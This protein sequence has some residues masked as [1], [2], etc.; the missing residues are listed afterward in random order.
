[1]AKG[2]TMTDDIELRSHRDRNI[3]SRKWLV[4]RMVP[5]G[6][7]G[8]LSG[9]WGTGKTTVLLDLAAALSSKGGTFA[10][11]PMKTRGVMLLFALEGGDIVQQQLE[12]VSQ[13][14]YDRKPI[15]FLY[16]SEKVNLLDKHGV[17]RV[18][19]IAKQAQKTA[20]DWWQLP[21]VAVAFD[22]MMKAAGYVSEGAEQDNVIGARV[23][24]ALQKIAEELALTVVGVD[25]YGKDISKGTRGAG[26]KEDSADF[27]IALLGERDTSGRVKNRRMA[28]RKVRG[29]KEGVEFAFDL[30]VIDIGVDEDGDPDTSVAVDWDAAPRLVPKANS[31]KRPNKIHRIVVDMINDGHGEMRSPYS[32]M[33]PVKCI[34]IEDVRAEHYR[35]YSGDGDT[36]PK[37]IAEAKK[38]KWQRDMKAAEDNSVKV[39]D[40]WCWL[41]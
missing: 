23:M 18:L 24:Q 25:H 12:A 37:K 30:T 34:K 14:K 20:M 31:S 19:T 1:M 9:Q 16:T 8:L 35:Q 13:Q 4:K 5:A 15:P 2:T 10:G 21:L 6:T 41:I 38:K 28:V 32:D 29:G 36:D 3:P 7:S 17:E 27:V 33:K 26:A 40:G 39:R 11:Q 22:T